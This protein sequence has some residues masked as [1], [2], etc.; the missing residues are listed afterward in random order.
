MSDTSFCAS[1]RSWRQQHMWAK[2][3][4]FI[5]LKWTF[6]SLSLLEQH[7]SIVIWVGR[8][9]NRN[10]ERRWRRWSRKG[11]CEQEGWLKGLMPPH[12][13][14]KLEAPVAKLPLVFPV[15]GHLAVAVC[16]F[17]SI[18]SGNSL[19]PICSL[20][21]IS[22]GSIWRLRVHL[23]IHIL[24]CSSRGWGIPCWEFIWLHSLK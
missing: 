1:C 12:P 9:V 7:E 24:G 18:L 22:A 3:M 4:N 21:Y 10:E 15:I 6:S 20:S 19:P 17:Q 23:W 8:E 11:R 14:G 13:G 5:H 2:M 16:Y